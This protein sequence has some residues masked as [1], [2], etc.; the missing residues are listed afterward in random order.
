MGSMGP[1]GV[2]KN[3]QK[4]KVLGHPR[5]CQGGQ[6]RSWGPWAP[7][8]L[9]KMHKNARCWATPEAAKVA[10]GPLGTHGPHWGGQKCLKI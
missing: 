9:P 7:L 3:I 5:G 4:Y 8:G 2:T 10:K 6:E 1:T